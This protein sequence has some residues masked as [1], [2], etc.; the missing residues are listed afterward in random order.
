MGYNRRHVYRNTQIAVHR[1]LL[2]WRAS[3]W[4]LVLL[5]LIPVALL[6][7]PAGKPADIAARISSP[8]KLC[9][10]GEPC[11]SGT[12]VLSTHAPQ[13]PDQ[14]Y[15]TFCFACHATGVSQSPILG[16]IA[17]WQPR[18]QKGI[19]VLYASSINGLGLMPA[20]GTCA[21]CSDDELRAVVDYMAKQS[22]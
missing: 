13:S 11:V 16:D 18:L 2:P 22:R 4:I 1:F 20:R 10:M 21:N 14:I 3:R 7:V 6:A 9:L 12:A 19:D 5:A 17:A 8:A 15:N